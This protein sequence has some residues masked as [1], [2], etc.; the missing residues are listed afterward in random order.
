MLVVLFV[1]LWAFVNAKVSCV[2]LNSL[3]PLAHSPSPPLLS[4]FRSCLEALKTSTVYVDEFQRIHFLVLPSSQHF[5]PLAAI[6]CCNE[7]PAPPSAPCRDRGVLKAAIKQL[8]SMPAAPPQQGK[9]LAK[10]RRVWLCFASL[11][12]GTHAHTQKPA[13]AQSAHT[14]TTHGAFMCSRVHVCSTKEKQQD[15]ALTTAASA[16]PTV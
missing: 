3:C 15:G 7:D 1:L 8:W 6:A 2:H 5:L 13:M 12:C 10:P 11:L 4:S 16:V 14:F 9:T